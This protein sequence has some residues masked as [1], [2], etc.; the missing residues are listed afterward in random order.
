MKLILAINELKIQIH[1]HIFTMKKIL[2]GKIQIVIDTLI[3]PFYAY[4]Y[5][6]FSRFNIL[7][8]QESRFFYEVYKPQYKVFSI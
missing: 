3:S 4:V 8:W 5:N 6:V 7:I 1:I 2:M